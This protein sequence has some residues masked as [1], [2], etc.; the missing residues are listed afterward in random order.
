MYRTLMPSHEWNDVKTHLNPG[1]QLIH[2]RYP[3]YL[4]SSSN[5]QW[6]SSL[7]ISS[8]LLFDTK[9]ITLFLGSYTL[10]SP[11]DPKTQWSPQISILKFLESNVC[12]CWG[13]GV[14]FPTSKQFSST[15]WVSYISTQF[16]YTLPGDIR[17]HLQDTPNPI[18][19]PAAS[20]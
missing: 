12:M 18:L 13:S 20:P 6:A 17:S 2:L 11:L 19:T 4:A 9:G 10:L 5:A 8:P 16:W 14:E 7:C 15:S 1:A 3:F